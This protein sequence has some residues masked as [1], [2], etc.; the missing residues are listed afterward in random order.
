MKRAFL[1]SIFV[2]ACLHGGAAEF[3]TPTI[4]HDPADS[5]RHEDLN[6]VVVRAVKAGHRAPFA[7]STLQ[8][9]QIEEQSRSG[10]EIPFLLQM[11]PSVVASSDNGLG[12]GTCYL[13]IRGSADSRINFTLDGVPLN[14][15]EDQQV[16]WA[17]MNGYAASLGSV[18]VQRG[19]GASTN[20]SGAFGATVALTGKAPSTT[21]RLGLTASYGSYNTLVTTATASTGLL[22]NHLVADGRFTQTSTDGYIDCTGS[23]SGSFYG[24]LTWYDDNVVVRYKNYGNYEKTDQAWDGVPAAMYDAGFRRFNSLNE[25]YDETDKKMVKYP[26]TTCDNY[27]QDHN[28]LSALFYMGSRWR[29]TLTLHYTHGHGYY[30][31]FKPNCKISKFGLVDATVKKSDLVRKKGL[32]NDTWGEVW[33]VNYLDSHWDVTGGL[34]SQIFNGNHYGYLTYLKELPALLQAGDYSY[35]NSEAHKFD[36]SGFTKATYTF[37]SHWSLYADVQYRFVHYRTNG[38]NDKFLSNGAGGY[39][40]QP[41]DVNEHFNFFNP[42]GGLNW[43]S[44]AHTAYLSVAVGGRE[45]SR[46][47]YTDNGSYPFPKHETLI[48]YEAGYSVET[49]RFHAA[50]NL[51]YMDYHNQLVQTGQLSDIGEALTTNIKHSYRMGVELTAGVNITSW[52]DVQAAASLSRNRIK[53]FNEVV[54]DWDAPTGSRTLHYNSTPLPFSPSVTANGSLNFH[55]RRAKASFLTYYV[56]RQYLDNTG[57]RSRSLDS[58]CVSNLSLSYNLPVNRFLG[59]SEVQLGAQIQNLFNEKYCANG[60]VYSAL[61]E[62]SGYTNDNRYAEIGYFPMAGTTAMG[63]VSILF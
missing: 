25:Y 62:S 4:Y 6:E 58:Y 1:F 8:P 39:V 47:N 56:G 60:W 19:V 41:L 23:R 17:N 46:N 2:A 18:Q 40:N 42:K 5:L 21:P 32:A 11:S 33:N 52:L 54:D 26:F 44:G 57:S 24:G 48:D 37:L 7:V 15:N 12:I 51:Y 63:S 34:S 27:W 9:A 31:N 55:Y 28:I 61:S 29:S 14:D 43:H 16:F 13:R 53:D 36:F 45:P 10:R 20:G 35:Y 59:V 22:W 3:F 49:A 30:S 50:A 38:L